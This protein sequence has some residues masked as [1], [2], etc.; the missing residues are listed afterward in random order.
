MFRELANYVHKPVSQQR[1]DK[2]LQ[3]LDQLEEVED[4]RVLVQA[5]T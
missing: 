2:V 1:L 4:V 3:L 5:L